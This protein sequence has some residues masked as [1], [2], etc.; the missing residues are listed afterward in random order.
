MPPKPLQTMMNKLSKYPN[1]KIKVL[2]N[3]KRMQQKDA[4]S[5]VNVSVPTF[6]KWVSGNYSFGLKA[7]NQLKRLFPEYTI[8]YILNGVNPKYLPIIEYS[9]Q[10]LFESYELEPKFT[11]EVIQL[12]NR[13]AELLQ[14]KEDLKADKLYFKKQSEIKAVEIYELKQKVE[15]LSHKLQLANSYNK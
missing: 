3:E 2:L 6:S 4:A 11:D 14:D 13:V 9:K 12:N 8:E 15:E 7:I 10:P 5:L 1:N